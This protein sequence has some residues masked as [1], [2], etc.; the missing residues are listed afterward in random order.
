MASLGLKT[1]QPYLNRANSGS[2]SHPNGTINTNYQG[3]EFDDHVSVIENI[4]L[5]QQ[6]RFRQRVTGAA[7]PNAPSSRPKIVPSACR[8]HLWIFLSAT[9]LFRR[10]AFPAPWDRISGCNEHGENA[11][12]LNQ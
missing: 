7:A 3:D 2:W 4:A 9:T 1:F 5:L 11:T 10:V 8:N 6:R 12:R